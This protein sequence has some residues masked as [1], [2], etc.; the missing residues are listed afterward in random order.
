V[1]PRTLSADQWR[2]I[3]ANCETEIANLRKAIEVGE[4]AERT[5]HGGFAMRRR[6]DR[7]RALIKEHE[8]AATTARE[9]LKELP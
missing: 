4:E 1:R 3:V 6:L 2:Q 9:A 5:G 7:S 8:K